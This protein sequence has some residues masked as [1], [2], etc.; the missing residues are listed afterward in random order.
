MIGFFLGYAALAILVSVLFALLEIQIE[1]E[2]G[3][4]AKLPTFK[5]KSRFFPHHPW[6]LTGYHIYLWLFLFLMLHVPRLFVEWGFREELEVLS[7]YV[8]ILGLED[9]LWFVLNP[10]FTL[11]KF[12]KAHVWWHLAWLGPVPVMY[13]IGITLWAILFFWAQAI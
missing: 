8:L 10:Y 5:I 13:F 2:H 3:L 6:I 12:K 7:F 9:F 11:K 1:G 4:A